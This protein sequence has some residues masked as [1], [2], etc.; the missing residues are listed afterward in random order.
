[1]GRRMHTIL[2]TSMAIAAIAC[3]RVD[4]A[5][6]QADGPPTLIVMI[7]VDQLGGD[8]LDRYEPALTAGG[9]RRFMDQGHRFTQASHAHAMPETA[10]GHATLATGVFPARHGI[11][12]NNW[13]Q[14]VGFDWITTYSVADSTSP[15]LGYEFEPV[16]D[17]TLEG[18]SPRNL[19]RPS[20]ADW[21]RSQDPGART[22]SISKKD[23]AAITMAG[24]TD[25]NV[26][27]LLDQ[28]ATF[29]TSTFYAE[30][31]PAWMQRFNGE[32]MPPIASSPVWISEV[33][34]DMRELAEAD[35]QPYEGG[36]RSMSSFP[37]RG[38]EEAGSPVGSQDF[39]VWAFDQPRADDAVL[40]LAKTAILQLELGQRGPVD[41][42]AV[43][44]SAL[45]EVGHRF[46][47]LSQEALSTLIHL[48]L[49]L[50][51]LLTYLDTEVGQGRWVAGIAG[52]HGV[53]IPPEAARRQGN[54]EAERIDDSD[55]LADMGQLLRRAAAQGGSPD[56]I[57]ERLALAIEEDGLVE[58]AYTHRELLYGGEPSDS[59]AVLFR[60]SHYPGRAWGVLSRFGV[61]V[62][63]GEGDLVTSFETGTDHGSPYWYDRHV[64]MMLLGPG[65]VPGETT[66]PVYT[67]DFAPTLA[68]L[69]GIRFPND[70]D[71]RRLF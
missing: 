48:D 19:M 4:P 31:Y 9:F 24:H 34:D 58:Q 1:M 21:V 35:A 40:E 13:R 7:V 17:P 6:A 33:P 45:D 61:E 46:G 57:A 47:P 20:M 27:W 49:V 5:M 22:V 2:R 54:R 71:G 36:G 14:R 59:F 51:N 39:N 8:L 42:L 53:A 62:R 64:E 70:L 67:V 43:S 25:S 65:V 29:V 3:A 15:I 50:A 23:R 28:T 68:A 11:V 12:S 10:A 56:A 32:V 38:T 69:G 60:N 55:V 16:L 63:Y 52:D 44:F 30:R 41:L 37:H 26:W 66:S 18:R